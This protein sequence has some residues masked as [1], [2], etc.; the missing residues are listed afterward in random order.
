MGKTCPKCHATDAEF[1][2]NKARKDGLAV[3][4]R[5][6]TKAYMADKQ[7]DKIRWQ[8][9]RD[10][11]RLRNKAYRER[12]AEALRAKDNARSPLKRMKFAAEIRARNIAR[13][14]GERRATPQWADRAA[15]NALYLEAKRLEAE[16]GIKRHIDHQV[17]L[18][19]PLV[20]GLHV[21]ANLQIL[22]ATENMQKHNAFAVE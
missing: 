21:P 8:E 5:A 11:E 3:Y 16:D 1:G 12:E 9:R 17:P 10:E 20:C 4:C 22:T 6:C 2:P 13:R 18:K 15:M 19:H 7:Y 14:H